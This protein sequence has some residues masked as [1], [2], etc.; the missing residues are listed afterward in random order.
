MPY[1]PDTW[2]NGDPTKPL[3]AA[4]LTKLGGQYAAAME[5]VA[6]GI[7][8]DTSDIGAALKG[9]IVAVGKNAFVRFVDQNGNPLPP[10]SLTTIHVNTITG[11]VDDITF[12][13][14]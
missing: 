14:A 12:E 7:V 2:V 11:D 4:R 6:T 9:T 13:E 1:T 8:D 10:G 5:D 3:N